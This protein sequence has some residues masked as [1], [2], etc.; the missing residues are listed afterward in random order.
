[1]TI[2]P[3]RALGL[4]ALIGAAGLMPACSSTPA[5][6]PESGARI[7]GEYE[8]N[9]DAWRSVGYRWE[10]TSRPPLTRNG[11]IAFADA[12]DDVVV[13]QDSGAMVS[14]IENPTGR[15]RWNTQVAQTNTRFLGNTRRNGSIVV[16]N[17]TELYELD[18]RTGNTLDRS[19]VGGIATTKPV[20]FGDRAVLATAAGRIVVIDTRTDLRVYEYQ[21]DGLIETPPHKVDEDRVAVISTRGEIR[22][23]EVDSARSLSS[24]R[25]SGDA[26]DWLV[27]E[28][29]SLFIGSLDQSIYGYDMFDGHRMWRVRSSAPVIVQPVLI[30]GVLYATTA[31]LGLAAIDSLSGEILWNNAAIGG[32]VVTTNDGDLMVWTGGDLLR[33]DA[34]RGDVIASTPIQNVSGLRA[35][36]QQDGNIFAI[37]ATGALAKFSPR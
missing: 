22:T 36:A 21:F 8:V 29:D 18:L 26:G 3:P 1:M 10:W 25:I 30:D 32:W 4:L 19:P 9:H 23:L 37:T 11:V 17:E 7:A 33:V 6:P 13:V 34:A 20:F 16:T 12:F 28:G 14:V 2:R 31:D 5:A 27:S 24:A 35:D 15:I